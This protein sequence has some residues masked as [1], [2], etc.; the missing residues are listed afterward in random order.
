MSING[1]L[2]SIGLIINLSELAADTPGVHYEQLERQER[3]MVIKPGYRRMKLFVLQLIALTSVYT[4]GAY[5]YRSLV[6]NTPTSWLSIARWLIEASC[7]YQFFCVLLIAARMIPTSQRH[8]NTH[9]G[10]HMNMLL[11]IKMNQFVMMRYAEF[12]SQSYLNNTLAGSFYLFCDKPHG[13]SLRKIFP[14]HF[15]PVTVNHVQNV[16]R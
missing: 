10:A 6:S 14:V 4:L 2:H 13:H 15:M 12:H 1:W 8:L 3:E 7:D 9:F 11:L 5:Y 16:R